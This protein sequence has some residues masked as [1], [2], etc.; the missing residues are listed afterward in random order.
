MLSPRFKET[1]TAKFSCYETDTTKHNS[2][3]IFLDMNCY[4]AADVINQAIFR[5]PWCTVVDEL[6][7]S[8]DEIVQISDFENI[9]WEPVLQG[10]H[11]ASSYIVR[12]GLSRKAQ[13]GKYVLIFF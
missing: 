12:K 8:G 7:S 10:K 5:R 13:F 2:A 3:A 6:A 11:K 1:K 9:E 4:Y